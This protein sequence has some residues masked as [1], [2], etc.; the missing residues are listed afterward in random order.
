MTQPTHAMSASPMSADGAKQPAGQL[1]WVASILLAVGLT[2]M[3]GLLHGRMSQ[4]WGMDD[5]MQAAA[6]RLQLFP[7]QVG[8][9]HQEATYELG[10]SAMQLLEC[11]GYIHRGYRHQETGDYLK[12][13]VMVGPGSKM[14][15]HVPEICYEASNFSLLGDRKRMSIESNGEEQSFWSVMFQVNDV[16]E[17]RVRVLYGWSTGKSWTAPRLPRWSVAGYPILYKLQLSYIAEDA[18]AQDPEA[19]NEML[20][21]FM[22]EAVAILQH[23][24]EP[25]RN[26]RPR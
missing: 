18:M 6:E 5:R 23:L 9:W 8:P 22:R 21:N 2:L 20:A 15:I 14:S 25:C 3:S 11:Q 1:R 19:D 24:T 7:E 10:D 17:R 12:L 4:R 13:A 16:S 26:L